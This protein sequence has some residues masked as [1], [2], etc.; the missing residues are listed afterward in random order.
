MALQPGTSPVRGKV[1]LQGASEGDHLVH[2]GAPDLQQDRQQ[3]H[4]LLE[5]A[6]STQSV[7]CAAAPCHTA[8]SMRLNTSPDIA[9]CHTLL[10]LPNITP[11]APPYAA[12][13]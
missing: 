4:S 2:R 9:K 8:G 5:M 11:Q 10:K 3:R 1:T 13:C 7:V 6:T 12:W